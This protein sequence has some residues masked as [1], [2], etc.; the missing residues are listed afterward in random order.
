MRGRPVLGAISGLFL[1][2]FIAIALFQWSIRPLEA[3]TVYGLPLLFA[4]IGIVLG[5]WAP[6]GRKRLEPAPTAPTTIEEP[7]PPA[8]MDEPEPPPAA[9]E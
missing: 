9:D 7:P 6:F 5:F 8:A 2:L 3:A 4:V 1:G